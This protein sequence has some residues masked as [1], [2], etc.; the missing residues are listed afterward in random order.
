MPTSQENIFEL[1][2]VD[3]MRLIDADEVIVPAVAR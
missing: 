3:N 1:Y 2:Y